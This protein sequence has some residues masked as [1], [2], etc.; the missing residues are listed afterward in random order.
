MLKRLAAL[1]AV[2]LIALPAYGADVSA[3]CKDWSA[4]SNSNNPS[5]ST[6]IGTGLDDNL[7]E[8]QGSVI[9]CLNYKGADIASAGTTDLGAVEGLAHTVTGTTTITSFGTV[10]AGVWKVVIFSGAL[11]LTHNATSLILPGAANITTVAGDVLLT[12]SEGSGNWRVWAYIRGT[13]GAT[14]TKQQVR[15]VYTSGSGTHTITSG[16]TRINVRLV[17]GGGGGGAAKSNSGGN[18]GDST[19]S[20]VTAGGGGGGFTN[21]GQ[22]GASGIPTGGDIN[23]RGGN[24]G[25][26]SINGS[27]NSQGGAGG[28]SAFGG[29]GG[30]SASNGAGLAGALNSGGGGSGGGDT[31]ANTSGGGGGAGGYAE[32]LIVSPAASYSYAVGAAGTAGAAGSNAGGAGAAGIIIVDEFFN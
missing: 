24:G 19:F 3:A 23:I 8:I 10:R 18:G 29:G 7:R 32:K 17:G 14:A 1:L 2:F 6:T 27:T 26:G 20:T 25:A 5:G 9:R 30:E 28:S 16:A 13:T 11:T 31:A 22:G 15:T 4:T 21:G 12:M